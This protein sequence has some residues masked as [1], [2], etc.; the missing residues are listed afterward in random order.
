MCLRLAGVLANLQKKV[1]QCRRPELVGGDLIRSIRGWQAFTALYH[2]DAHLKSD[3]R[4]LGD[5]DFVEAV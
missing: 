4:I 5:S 1:N 3:E 2:T